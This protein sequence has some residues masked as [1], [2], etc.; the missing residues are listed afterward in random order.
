MASGNRDVIDAYFALVATAQLEFLLLVRDCEQMNV[1][2]RVL[3]KR[4]G[5]KQ[6]VLAALLGLLDVDQ[7]E[8]TLALLEDVRVALLA[9]LAFKFLPV[10]ARDILAVLLDVTLRLEPA[11][12]AHVV[13]VAD[14]AGTL[15]RQDE[16]VVICLLGAPTEA[17][18]NLLFTSITV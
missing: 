16:W 15:A 12:E 6:N 18:L 17:T 9:D 10:V 11:L 4:H 14:C 7:F 3:I 5:L 2:A 1:T 13:D 8:K